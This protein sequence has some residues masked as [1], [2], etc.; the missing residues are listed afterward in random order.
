MRAFEVWAEAVE[1]RIGPELAE[2]LGAEEVQR[3]T[4]LKGLLEFH[5]RSDH[6]REKA[7]KRNYH[8]RATSENRG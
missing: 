8:E 3:H 1:E 7:T 5:S 4:V 2:H 6:M